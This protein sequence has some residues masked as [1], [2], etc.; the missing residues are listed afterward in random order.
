MFSFVKQYASLNTIISDY[1][2]SNWYR[3]YEF[4]GCFLFSIFNGFHFDII[5]N[6]FSAL[7][8]GIF[9]RLLNLYSFYVNYIESGWERFSRWALKNI[10]HQ[11]IDNISSKSTQKIDNEILST[12][13]NQKQTKK[14]NATTTKTVLNARKFYRKYKMSLKLYSTIFVV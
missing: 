8:D 6:F 13:N 7:V 10:S 9:R 1:I 4:I 12:R 2:C 11:Y 5:C 14:Q 3:L